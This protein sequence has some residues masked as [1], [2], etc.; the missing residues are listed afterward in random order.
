MH[1]A[2]SEPLALP[3]AADASSNLID[4]LAYI[5]TCSAA[6][7]QQAESMIDQELQAMTREGKRAEQYTADLTPISDF[8]KFK[9]RV[10][11]F[12][13]VPLS[14]ES[15]AVSCQRHGST[16][17]PRR[18][19]SSVCAHHTHGSCSTEPAL[20]PPSTAT[21]KVLHENHMV[22]R[23]MQYCGGRWRAYSGA[24]STWQSWTCQQQTSKRHG[25]M[26]RRT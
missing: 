8:L 7:R 13:W 5:D 25:C 9:A 6:E 15:H 2:M 1:A 26:S 21:F 24:S 17:A 19:A 18:P 20:L 4:A 22:C 3:G 23:T 14:A 12:L 10:M 11:S 16:S